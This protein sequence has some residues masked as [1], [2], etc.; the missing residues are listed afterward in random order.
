MGYNSFFYFSDIWQVDVPLLTST[1]VTDLEFPP[2][3]Y[4]LEMYVELFGNCGMNACLFPQQKSGK[5][6]L[7]ILK[8]ELTSLIV[9]EQWME[10]MYGLSIHV[11]PCNTTTRDFRLLC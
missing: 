5:K 3:A 2:S 4:S 7:K 6:L 10:N 11:I 9:L 8:K 1:T